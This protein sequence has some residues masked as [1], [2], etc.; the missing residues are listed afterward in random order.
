MISGRGRLDRVSG[1]G[2]VW[3]FA[4]HQASSSAVKRVPA[5]GACGTAGGRDSGAP[6]ISARYS[7]AAPRRRT[8]TAHQSVT[9]WYTTHDTT[10]RRSP[11][12]HTATRKHGGADRSKRV[13]YMARCCA[14]HSAIGSGCPDRSV[15]SSLRDGS[16]SAMGT[17]RCTATPSTSR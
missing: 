15:T 16:I 4:S 17:S 3:N 14:A 1:R 11:T 7:F 10:Q 12:F 8:S 9:M 13:A 2:G 5:C 6:A